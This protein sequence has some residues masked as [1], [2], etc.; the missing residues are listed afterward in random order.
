L[1]FI[2]H[3]KPVTKQELKEVDNSY[4]EL[5]GNFKAKFGSNSYKKSGKISRA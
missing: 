4:L 1:H 2:A 3:R 5:V